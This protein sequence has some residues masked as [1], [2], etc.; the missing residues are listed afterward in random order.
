M[1]QQGGKT[2]RV[3]KFG[4]RRKV[5]NGSALMTHGKLKKDDLIK[6]KRG[7]IVSKKRYEKMVKRFGGAEEPKEEVTND[8][9]ELTD[10]T[11]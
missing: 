9:Q 7:R 3:D 11:I 6:T 2:R 1:D 8:V 5:W 4:S 10:E